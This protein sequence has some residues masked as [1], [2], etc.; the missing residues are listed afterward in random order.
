M[1]NDRLTPPWRKYATA[2]ILSGM[3]LILTVTLPWTVSK[4]GML[5]LNLLAVMIAA[6]VGGFGPGL[7]ATALSALGAIY[8]FLPPLYSLHV[9]SRS[10]VVYLGIFTTAACAAAWLLDWARGAATD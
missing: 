7:L 10:D 3:M 5:L 8:F 6:F 4:P 9:Q 2:C 1:T